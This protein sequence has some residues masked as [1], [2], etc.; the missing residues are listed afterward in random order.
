MGT[1]KRGGA[2]IREAG[3]EESQSDTTEKSL[4]LETNKAPSLPVTTHGPKMVTAKEAAWYCLQGQ[5]PKTTESS[6]VPIPITIC[7]FKII[8]DTL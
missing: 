4:C 2:I 1:G 7:A 3:A 5:T 8:I 6:D